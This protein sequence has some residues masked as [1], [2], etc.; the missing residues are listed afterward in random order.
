MTFKNTT[1]P[2]EYRSLLKEIE[3]RMVNM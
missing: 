1:L 3:E 2:G